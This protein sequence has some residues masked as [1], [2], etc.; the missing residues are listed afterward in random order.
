MSMT[1]KTTKNNK[2]WPKEKFSPKS[3]KSSPN[4]IK[5]S[6]EVRNDVY[7]GFRVFLE[8]KLFYFFGNLSNQFR[9]CFGQNVKNLTCT[10]R[11]VN[12]IGHFSFVLMSYTIFMQKIREV[13]HVSRNLSEFQKLSFLPYWAKI[14]QLPFRSSQHPQARI[15]FKIA[16]L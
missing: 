15:L 9:A 2:K 8:K 7:N 13:T 11:S 3:P 10:I 4:N 16:F 14:H 1:P 6:V 5:L 12:P